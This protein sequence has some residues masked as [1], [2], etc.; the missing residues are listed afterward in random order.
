LT[1]DFC[2]CVE[3]RFAGEMHPSILQSFLELDEPED[4]VTKLFK[5]Y[6]AA[7]EQLV[8][9]E[10]AAFFLAIS[11]RP[12]QKPVPFIPVLDADFGVWFKKDSL[13]PRRTSKQSLIRICNTSSF[14]R[15]LSL[16]SIASRSTNQSRKCSAILMTG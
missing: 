5:T 9:S 2:R 16:S 14:S 6:P 1:G 8:V 7:C 3:E 13:W 11:Q 10:D 4:F 15:A 12:G